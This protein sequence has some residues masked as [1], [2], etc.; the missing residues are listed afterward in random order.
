MIPV[1]RNGSLTRQ[2]GTDLISS[3]HGE[4]KFHLGKTGQIAPVIYL[5]LFTFSFSFL[6]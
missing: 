5:D 4:I 3:L 2:A 6:L 1:C